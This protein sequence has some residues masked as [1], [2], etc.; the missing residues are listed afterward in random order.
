VTTIGAAM[1]SPMAPAIIGPVAPAGLS[2]SPSRRPS[3]LKAKP[4]S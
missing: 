4:A 1:A 3:H 2:A